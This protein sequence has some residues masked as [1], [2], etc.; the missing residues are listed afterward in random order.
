[1][2]SVSTDKPGRRRILFI[3]ADGKRRAIRLGKVSRK[4]A[5]TVCGYVESLVQSANTKTTWE[6]ETATWIASLDAVLYDKLAAV[7]LVPVRETPQD[8]APVALGAF[9]ESYIGGRA[10]LKP[11]TARNYQVTRQHLVSHFGA[12]KAMQDITPGDADDW[13]QALIRKGLSAAT[14]SREVKRARQYFRAAVRR[15]IIDAN[16]FQDLKG[17]KQANASR[18]FFVTR[19]TTQAV[20]D[21]CPDGEWRLI[22]ALSRYGGLRCP[23]EHLALRWDGIDWERDRMTVYSPKTEHHEGGESRVVP[24]FPELRPYLAEAFEKAP[25]GA[26]YAI[27]RYR[28][29]NA[30]LRTQ[31]ERIIRRAAVAPW[32]KLFQNMRASRETELTAEYPL[33][34]VCKW[35]GNSPTVAQAHYLQVTEADFRRAVETKGGIGVAQGGAESGALSLSQGAQNPAQ[36]V[37]ANSRQETQTG[38]KALFGNGLRPVVANRGNTLRVSLVPPRVEPATFVFAGK[39]GDSRCVCLPEAVPV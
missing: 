32:P 17:G 25:D 30:N 23:S 5:N 33:H 21:A 22:V 18:E 29:K 26:E 39:H 12:D 20:I 19:E 28:C 24:I 14:I 2:A 9:L 3:G 31:F 13:R 10:D 35:I 15:K 11:N 1:M 4:K 34:V 6:I 16:P 37:S 8:A 38:R 7:R 36:P 27:T